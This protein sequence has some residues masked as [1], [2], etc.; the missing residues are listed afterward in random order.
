MLGERGNPMNRKPDYE[1][2]Y[3]TAESQAG[4]PVCDQCVGSVSGT[5]A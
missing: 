5:R 2:L 1:Q 3:A 4:Y